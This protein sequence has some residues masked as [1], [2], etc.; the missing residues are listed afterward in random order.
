MRCLHMSGAGND[1][2]VIDGRGQ[3]LNYETL[4]I[5][6]CAITGADG[7]MALD[8]S[9]KADF[10]L[11]YY[12]A[13]GSRGEMCGNGSRCICKFAYDLGIVGN[14]MTIET[15]AGIVPGWRLNDTLF[16][17][18]LT[19]PVDIDLEA[20]PQIAYAVCGVPHAIAEV[21]GLKW[22]MKD[23]LRE[24]AKSLR[25]DPVFPKGANVDFYAWENDTTVR[26]LSYER[27]VEDY[28]L[29]C[30]TGCGALTAVLYTA[31]QLPGKTL[32][33]INPGGTL[34]VTVE[35]QGGLISGLLLEGPAEVM[36]EYDI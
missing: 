26:V 14:E 28:T 6:L 32:T 1:F 9:D 20:K 19:R 11:H 24:Q 8:H 10:R 21:P 34:R 4:S 15:D 29:A 36:G 17:V 2:M 7:F 3:N 12:N 23:S 27:G 35:E 25:F 33:A 5:E 18:K 30:G 31:G 22:E 13:D 16:R